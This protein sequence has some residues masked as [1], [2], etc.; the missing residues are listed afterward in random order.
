MTHD[1]DTGQPVPDSQEPGR[2]EQ[3]GKGVLLLRIILPL[4]VVGVGLFAAFWLMKTGPEA[5][6]RTKSRNAA[7]VSVVPLEYKTH[8]IHIEA[9]GT[10]R[11]KQE[12]LLKPQLSGEI[13]GISDEFLPGGYF[14]A[15]DILLK[16]DETDYRLAVEQLQDEVSRAEADLQLERGR[17]LVAIKEFELLGETLSEEE[18]ALMLRQPQLES[19]RAV[20]STA[21]S[22][23]RQAEIDLQRSEIRAPFNA[24]VLSREV[25]LGARVTAG[26]ELARLVGTDAYWVEVSVPVS[27]LRWIDIPQTLTE[28]GAAARI[29]DQAAWGPEVSRS[30][31]VVRLSAALEEKG[32]MARLLIEVPDPLSLDPE[33]SGQPGL[34]LNSYVRVEIAGQKLAAAVA[35]S[36]DLLRDNETVW[37]MNAEDRLDIRKVEI[38]YSG[39]QEVFVTAGLNQGER[40]VT[41]LLSAPVQGMPLRVPG[42]SRDRQDGEPGLRV[43]EPG[44]Q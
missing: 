27:R 21:K 29:Y 30:G 24:V 38:A 10:V 26:S 16:I 23:L 22:K 20:L 1:P 40:L 18:Q 14:S 3:P 17:Q 37:I 11:P 42:D 2:Q 19:L 28:R 7:L 31:R 41:S 13:V 9:M 25:N 5:K 12:V 4:L 39:E 8:R 35:L 43:E 33:N 36:R 6:P 32:R 15:G 34:L 44:A